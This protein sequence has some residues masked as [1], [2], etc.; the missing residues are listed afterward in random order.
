M[1]VGAD[2]T[3]EDTVG[4]SGPRFQLSRL[5]VEDGP[6]KLELDV[7][8]FEFIPI[9]ETYQSIEKITY[10]SLP[11]RN[12]DESVSKYIPKAF[13][14]LVPHMD[15]NLESFTYGEPIREPSRRRAEQ[16]CKLKPG[17]WIFFVA[18]LAPYSEK[19]YE[20]RN[21]RMI[22]RYQKGKM[23]KFVVGYYQ[24]YG[25]F[26][27]GKNR[28]SCR[29]RPLEPD[30]A[31]LTQLAREQIEQNAHFKRV[32]D[33]FVCAVGIKERRKSLLLEKGVRITEDGSPFKPN[34]LGLALYGN[35]GFP[36][37]HKPLSSDKTNLLL[38]VFNHAL[39]A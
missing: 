34:S 36:R 11:S 32:E 18:S 31:P 21:L 19:A 13:D 6:A 5:L 39:L 20:A 22:S 23:A 3:G 10:K 9:L 33:E 8:Q 29:I 1:H 14:N 2:S 30:V 28:N 12:Q 26:K 15:P 38:A 17:D 25:C 4:V 24:I 16:L 7:C 35:V 27:V 37:G